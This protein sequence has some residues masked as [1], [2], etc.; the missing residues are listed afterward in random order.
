LKLELMRTQRKRSH[1]KP[2]DLL[3]SITMW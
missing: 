3:Q 1:V 2:A